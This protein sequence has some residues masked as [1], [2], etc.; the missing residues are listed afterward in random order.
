MASAADLIRAVNLGYQTEAETLVKRGAKVA[1]GVSEEMHLDGGIARLLP[2]G[3]TALHV[4]AMGAHFDLL[5]FMIEH[6]KEVAPE[7]NNGATPLQLAMEAGRK[8]LSTRLRTNCMA[9]IK[10]LLEWGSILRVADWPGLVVE[11][12]HPGILFTHV[13][14]FDLS[15]MRCVSSTF[16]LLFYSYQFISPPGGGKNFAHFAHFA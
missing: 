6:T 9:V 5:R 1:E 7:D 3:T 13:P 16:Q 10:A 11:R 14:P 2:K 15:S 8:N 12:D 4:A